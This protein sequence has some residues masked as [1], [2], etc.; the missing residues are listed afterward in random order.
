MNF[1]DGTIRQSEG[2]LWFDEGAARIRV[3][4]RMVD[5]IASKC[6]SAIVL[7][8]RPEAISSEHTGRFAS[9]DNAIRMMINVTEPLGD[10]MD[11]YLATERHPHIV[12]RI[13]AHHGVESNA[14]QLFYLDMD[15]I[16]FF[17][18]GSLG[19]NLT[20]DNREVEPV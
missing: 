8:V 9:A 2:A 14:E 3:P 13:D 1:M 4:D 15:R 16:H 7:G 10:K 17:D 12:A 19:K 5:K 11:L 20:L 18:T 6:D